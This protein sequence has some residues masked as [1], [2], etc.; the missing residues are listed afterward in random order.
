ME[1]IRRPQREAPPA[2]DHVTE[3]DRSHSVIYC[4]LLDAASEG[5]DW[6]E[7]AAVVLGI[8]PVAEPERAR[9]THDAHLERARWMTQV[10]YRELAQG[11]R[12]Q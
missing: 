9:R 11:I 1:A 8:D 12:W 4:R 5:A 6:R 10:G 3:Y 7:V 2:S